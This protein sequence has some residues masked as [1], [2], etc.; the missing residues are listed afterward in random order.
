MEDQMRYVGIDPTGIP[1]VFGEAKQND[2]A[3]TECQQA[4]QEYVEQRPDTG[5]VSSWRIE[6]DRWLR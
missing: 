1:R 3:Y 4:I 2:V 6:D 5:P